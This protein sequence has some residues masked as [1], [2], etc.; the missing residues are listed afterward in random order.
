MRDQGGI[1]DLLGL[2]AFVEAG[3]GRVAGQDGV[4]E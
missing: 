3:F 4:D 2:P 1:D